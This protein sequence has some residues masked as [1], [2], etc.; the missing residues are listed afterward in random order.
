MTLQ[1]VT[2]PPVTPTR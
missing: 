1:F 2:Y